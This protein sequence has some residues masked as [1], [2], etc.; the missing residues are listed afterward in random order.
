MLENKLYHL[1]TKEEI[2]NHFPELPIFEVWQDSNFA[3]QSFD[4][5]ESWY[6]TGRISE[7][8]YMAYCAIWRNTVPRLSSCLIEWEF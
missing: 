7:L 4:T 6:N 3:M 1:H 8:K 2:I 5:V